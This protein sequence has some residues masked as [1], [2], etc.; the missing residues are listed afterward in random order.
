MRKALDE[1]A[2]RGLIE[3]V[4]RVKGTWV[5]YVIFSTASLRGQRAERAEETWSYR[6]ELGERC[7]KGINDKEVE[8]VLF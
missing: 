5:R 4:S 3:V 8:L 7:K 1:E 2:K 6:P